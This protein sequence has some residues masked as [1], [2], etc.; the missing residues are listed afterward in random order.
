M[1]ADSRAFGDSVRRA[2]EEASSRVFDEVVGAAMEMRNEAVKSTPVRTGALRAA[3]QVETAPNGDGGT[4]DIVNATEYRDHIE[5]GTRYIKPQ[6]MIRPA[7]NLVLP[8][9][10]DRLKGL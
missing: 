6:P 3:W 8:R 10:I 7:L 5:Y 4:V 9:L 2:M 1:S